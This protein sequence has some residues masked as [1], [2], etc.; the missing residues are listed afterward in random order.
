M[1]PR[2]THFKLNPCTVGIVT[3]LGVASEENV[4]R[5]LVHK[6]F[7]NALMCFR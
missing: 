5:K 7:E 3:V 4:K 1:R 6:Y 2:L